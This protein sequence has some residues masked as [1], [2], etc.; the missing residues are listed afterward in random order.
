MTDEQQ[1]LPLTFEQAAVLS[2]DQLWAF[3]TPELLSVLTEDRRAERKPVAIH[4]PELSEYFSMWAN[5]A[6]EDP[7]AFFTLAP[8]KRNHDHGSST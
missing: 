3:A 4:A 1:Q 8:P 2:V 5:T 7:L 6:V